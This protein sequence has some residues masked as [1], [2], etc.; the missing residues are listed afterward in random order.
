MEPELQGPT[1]RLPSEGTVFLGLS[2]RPAVA[3]PMYGTLGSLD[4]ESDPRTVE[5]LL[6]WR[7]SAPK[8]SGD[9]DVYIWQPFRNPPSSEYVRIV[10]TNLDVPLKLQIFNLYKTSRSMESFRKRIGAEWLDPRMS[11]NAIMGA[12]SVTFSVLLDD[13][14]VFLKE[15]SKEISG[16]VSNI[17]YQSFK[18]QYPGFRPS[19]AE[20]IHEQ[21]RYSTCFTW[22]TVS[23][24]PSLKWQAISLN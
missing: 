24:V 23:R 15:A 17:F 22:M 8:Y 6:R 14:I 5:F 12:I 11:G 1:F 16:I 9:L 18:A 7:P 3:N 19:E 4:T 10:I 21:R 2:F 20:H 13:M